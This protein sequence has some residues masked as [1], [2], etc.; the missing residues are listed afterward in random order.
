MANKVDV[1]DVEGKK[2]ETAELPE[3]YFGRDVNVPLIHQVVKAQLAASRAGTAKA[4]TRGEVSGGG[5]K[6]W[7]QKGTGRARQGSIRAP[8]WAGGGVVHGPQPRSYAQRTPKKMKLG[9]LYSALSNRADA[10]R[11]L[12]VTGFIAEDKIS[13]KEARVA[14]DRLT[15][16]ERT[17]YVTFRG[18]DNNILSVRNLPNVHILYVDQLNTLDVMN[19][20]YVVF[21]KTALEQ[22]LA[23]KEGNK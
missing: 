22:F 18:D 20:E 10:D 6:P 23:A 4:K 5:K 2:V 21:H 19:S 7:R 17:L 11:I 12:V 14:V 16:G 9:A 13:T 15:A 1:L 8:Q 3:Q